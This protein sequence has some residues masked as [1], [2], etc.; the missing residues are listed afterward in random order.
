MLLVSQVTPDLLWGIDLDHNGYVSDD[1]RAISN[2]D[3]GVG[4]P[5]TMPGMSTPSLSVGGTEDTERGFYNDVTV[6]SIDPAS[7]ASDLITPRVS[8]SAANLTTLLENYAG[9]SAS[10]AQPIAAAASPAAGAGGGGPGAV[11]G[12]AAATT[13][14]NLYTLYT[15]MLAAG[16]TSDQFIQIED[17]INPTAATGGGGGGGGGGGTTTTT[18]G[19]VDVNTASVEGLAALTLPGGLSLST[20][21]AQNIIDQRQGI[22][23]SG[24]VTADTDSTWVYSLLTDLTPAQ[25]SSLAGQITGR[26][27]QYSADIVAVSGNGRGFK[28]VRIVVDARTIPAKIVYRR[29]LTDLGWPLPPEIRDALHNGEILDIGPNNP[30]EGITSF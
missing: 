4:L 23:P 15:R 29:D 19:L 3:S 2:G 27:F 14:T 5:M 28:R 17:Y 7:T 8:A 1:E 30:D 11:G 24:T 12:G 16:L 6:Y 22:V 9:M 26:S 25:L 10:Q 21:D 13:T 20:T 18:T